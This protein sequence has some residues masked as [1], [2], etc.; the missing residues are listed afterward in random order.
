[1]VDEW[2]ETSEGGTAR[3]V[4]WPV[5]PG[6]RAGVELKMLEVVA[7]HSRRQTEGHATILKTILFSARIP[8]HTHIVVSAT[9]LSTNRVPYKLRDDERRKYPEE[10]KKYVHAYI[11]TH[12]HLHRHTLTH[13]F[14]LVRCTHTGWTVAAVT[15][16]TKQH[17]HKQSLT[18]T[19]IHT[20][21]C[22]T[23]S[24][25]ARSAPQAQADNTTYMWTRSPCTDTPRQA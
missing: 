24:R 18:S 3:P 1:M 2:M 4:S 5:G 10:L 8:P 22:S 6:R 9:D 13:T 12:A 14:T 19:L 7:H 17:T 20:H 15:H 23:T 16:I 25:Y 11:H 21:I